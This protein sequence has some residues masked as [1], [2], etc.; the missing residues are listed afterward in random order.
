MINLEGI[1]RNAE[2]LFDM[3]PISEPYMGFFLNHPFT[4]SVVVYI[5]DRFVNV[6]EEPEEWRTYVYEII[7]RANSVDEIFAYIRSPWQLFFLKLVKAELEEDFPR[8]LANAWISSENPNKDPNVS[9]KELIKWF[10]EADKKGLMSEKELK[11][12]EAMPEY[13]H[14]YRGIGSESNPEGLSWTLSRKKAIWFATRWKDEGIVK[15]GWL[16][17][18]DCMAFFKGH[19]EEEIIA[20]YK[21]VEN[22]KEVAY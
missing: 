5:N 18:K 20:E 10:K 22:I 7:S 16:H 12:L 2:L 1:K 6:L 13:I 4:D 17:K 15:E 19:G 9:N 11:E 8:L 21:N 14:I 3:V